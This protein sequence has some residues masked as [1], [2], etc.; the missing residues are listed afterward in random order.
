MS[1][2]TQGAAIPSTANQSAHQVDSD[3]GFIIDDGAKHL[4]DG[5]RGE[6]WRAS[7]PA[8]E[9]VPLHPGLC[10]RITLTKLPLDPERMICHALYHTDIGLG[11]E[12]PSTLFSGSSYEVISHASRVAL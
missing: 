7:P 6:L 2:S 12:C 11:V 9:A 10:C 4:S 8:F 5:A 3:E 1:L